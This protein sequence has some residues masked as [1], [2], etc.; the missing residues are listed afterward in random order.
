[1]PAFNPVNKTTEKCVNISGVEPSVEV[2]RREFRIRPGKEVELLFPINC[3]TEGLY[4][5]QRFKVKSGQAALEIST[6]YKDPQR[7]G[8]V[9]VN[10][11]R[12]RST[13]IEDSDQVTVRQLPKLALFPGDAP[14]WSCSTISNKAYPLFGYFGG[15]DVVIG[16]YH[17]EAFS[18]QAGAEKDAEG[19]R[20]LLGNNEELMQDLNQALCDLGNLG[21]RAR[22]NYLVF[23][24][25]NPD[26]TYSMSLLLK[27]TAQEFD[28]YF[29]EGIIPAAASGL[30]GS[31]LVVAYV[32][33][34]SVAVLGASVL[35]T[36]TAGYVYYYYAKTAPQAAIYLFS[37]A[38]DGAEKSTMS[39][40][41]QILVWFK[42][43]LVE[44]VDIVSPFAEKIPQVGEVL[45]TTMRTEFAETLRNHGLTKSQA[46]L[47]IKLL[48]FFLAKMKRC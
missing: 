47:F 10:S 6:R 20:N 14:A 34:E 46:D 24:S 30:L 16:D 26:F 5:V 41:E 7:A 33:V 31:C 23:F 3:K 38:A 4:L 12:M 18:A 37:F 28:N 45:L 13:T 39:K 9:L 25:S 43:K 42:N 15:S 48:F 29:P 2:K 19:L 8:Q 22:A 27:E 44:L 21:E 36:A 40:Y 17:A 32:T 11:S 35:A 1:M